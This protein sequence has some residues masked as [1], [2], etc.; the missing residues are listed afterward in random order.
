[1]ANGNVDLSKILL[2]EFEARLARGDNLKSE[3]IAWL[4][5]LARGQ[6]MPVWELYK[7]ELAAEPRREKSIPELFA[8]ICFAPSEKHNR[9]AKEDVCAI[10]PLWFKRY[11]SPVSPVALGSGERFMAKYQQ[12]LERRYSY[13]LSYYLG[14]TLTDEGK[15]LLQEATAKKGV[16]A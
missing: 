10:F 15:K 8:E 16:L 11:V 2:D 4:L 5:N 12:E 7:R 14:I 3:E 6:I 9:V 1:M 13:N